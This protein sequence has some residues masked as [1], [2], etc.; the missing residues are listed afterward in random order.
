MAQF[1]EVEFP[2][3]IGFKAMGGPTFFTT[4]NE[5]FS[6]FEQ[7]NQNWA[8][9]RGKWNISLTTPGEEIVSQQEFID[10]L[11][12]IFLIAG[13]KENGFRLKDHKDFT[14]GFSGNPTQNL[15][16]TDGNTS[17]FQLTKSY[18][19]GPF[20]YLRNIYK[21][22]TSLVVDYQNIALADTVGVTAGLV[23]QRFN[24]GYL[25]G[26]SAQFTVDE[27]LG[28]IS[29]GK[30]SKWNISA[31]SVSGTTATV[32]YNVASGDAPQKNQQVNFSGF[33]L[34]FTPN[35]GSFIITSVTPTSATAGSF[36]ITNAAAV[37]GNN[38]QS[39]FVGIGQVYAA[40]GSVTAVVNSSGNVWQYTIVGQS[41]GQPI[42]AGM[43]IQ[44][45]GMQNAGNNGTFYIINTGGSGAAITVNVTNPNGV[46]EAG[47]S[48]IAF[49]DWVPKSGLV[50]SSTFQFHFPVR[51]DTDNLD[52]SLEDSNVA[53]GQPIIHWASIPLREIR[54]IGGITGGQG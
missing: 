43:R 47:S 4:V 26:G 38:L 49:A 34:G 50:L 45:S 30:Y 53:G 33:L 52:I 37:A 2:R 7:R 42:Q 15:A 17:L 13:G 48:G 18:V 14:S 29:F 24:P 41:G 19:I 39:G 11:T 23:A 28:I 27:T 40:T 12:A 54:I 21:P 51:F 3:T 8:T 46:A 20:G 16:V 9:A 6:G 44:F 35:N 25:G 10:Q 1:L 22:I 31:I 36:T 5:G 32:T